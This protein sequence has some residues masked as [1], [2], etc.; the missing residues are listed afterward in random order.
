MRAA[1]SILLKCCRLVHAVVTVPPGV[2]TCLNCLACLHADCFIADDL[3]SH[4]ALQMYPAQIRSTAHGISAAT[5]KV[6]SICVVVWLNY[7]GNRNKFWITWP[8]AL[9]GAVICW[10]FVADLT[11]LDLAEQVC[12]AF[13]ASRTVPMCTPFACCNLVEIRC[14]ITFASCVQIPIMYPSCVSV[15]Y[16]TISCSIHVHVTIATRVQDTFVGPLCI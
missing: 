5:G 6:G 16:P 11:G 7:L 15:Q 4:F 8:V 13:S 14:T 2:V 10:V 9:L 1:A 3:T 12:Q